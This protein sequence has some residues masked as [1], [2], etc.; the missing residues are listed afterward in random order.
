MICC[1]LGEANSSVVPNAWIDG[2]GDGVVEGSDMN[3]ANS[4]YPSAYDTIGVATEVG[5]ANACG[6]VTEA[7]NADEVGDS[8]EIG[9]ATEVGN[10]DEIGVTT[11]AGNADEVGDVDEVGNA[12]EVGVSGQI[13]TTPRPSNHTGVCTLIK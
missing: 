10:A 6:V 5:V 7:G 12:D 4:E 1:G 2:N 11:E 13:A 8:D 9:V 3:D